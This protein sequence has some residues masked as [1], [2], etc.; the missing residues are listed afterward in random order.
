MIAAV[1]ALASA[2]S[3]A[4]TQLVEADNDLL[5]GW[6]SVPTDGNAIIKFTFAVAQKNMPELKRRALAISTP[7]SDKYGAHMT[8][9]EINAL[10]APNPADVAVVTNLLTAKG[11]SFTVRNERVEV[12][13]SVA[14]ASTLLGTEVVRVH[15]DEVGDRHVLSGDPSLP[16]AVAAVFGFG[17]PLPK[18]AAI[19][20]ASPLVAKVTPEV[21]ASTY[22]IGNVSVAR[23]MTAHQAVAEFQ[24][25]R[26]NADDLSS[27]FTNLVPSAQPGD[28]KVLKF[29]HEDYKAGR[30]VE[31]ELDIQYIM[32]VSPGVG[33]EFWEWA[34]NDFCA[35]LFGFTTKLLASN[36]SVMSISYGW[37]GDLK[38]VG[39]EG[40]QVETID[41]NWAKLAARGAS[42]LIS[43]GDSGSGYKK[44]LFG[45]AKL[46]PS[47]PAS[48][49]WVTAVGA[50]CFDGA[51]GAEQ[52]ATTQF[53][54]GGGFSDLF[55]Q[56]DA[57][58]QADVVAKYVAMG[59]SLPKFP[60][61]SHFPATGRATPD[62][63]A[64]GEG[65]Q[66]KVGPSF[67]SVGGTSASC[68]AF[69]G[70]VSLLN[71]AR[72]Q[73]GKPVLGF[74]NPFLYSHG[75][76]FTDITEGTNAISRGGTPVKEGYAAA[77]GWDAATGLGVPIFSKLLTAALAA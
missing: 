51:V 45:G 13:T 69:A 17:L 14:R 72:R 29:V 64:L 6:A 37:Q 19:V 52:K 25:Q 54:S 77:P 7:G 68:P 67:E 31:A 32:G 15:H 53:G 57:T 76:A 42:V 23:G 11:I 24:G 3:A 55:D 48:S 20:S 39:C 10:T 5:E 65:Y 28:E 49:P 38:Q 47:W 26:M 71:E 2:L 18:R 21:L 40:P 63:S 4:P 62:V 50:T 61:S 16:S 73:A 70:M 34:A 75:D 22:A 8:V 36:V 60:A 43:S 56:S 33:T 58:W 66:V 12:E 1:F 46:Y 59:S 41:A 27:F 9:A 30:G 74:L 35:D 44:K